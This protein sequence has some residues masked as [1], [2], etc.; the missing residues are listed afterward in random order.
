[1]RILAC[2]IGL[3]L[4]AESAFAQTQAITPPAAKA[5]TPQEAKDHVGEIVTVEGVVCEVY[6]AKSGKVTF[7][8]MGGRYPNNPFAG[9]IFSDDAKKFSDVDFCNGKTCDVTGRVQLHDH[10][11]EI[12]L[13]DADQLKCK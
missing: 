8:D 1:M 2:G 6:H 13:N 5:I 3:A 9:V 10:A 4:L 11:P 12:I 7:I